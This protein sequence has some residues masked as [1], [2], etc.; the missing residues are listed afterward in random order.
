MEFKCKKLNQIQLSTN[1]SNCND[2]KI[3]FNC[4]FKIKS[5]LN[6]KKF[7]EIKMSKKINQIQMTKNEIQHPI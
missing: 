2:K 3:K 7:N 4:Q 6:V 5:S 1:L